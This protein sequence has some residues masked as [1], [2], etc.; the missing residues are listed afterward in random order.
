MSFIRFCCCV[1]NVKQLLKAKFV[2]YY[3]MTKKDAYELKSLHN[4]K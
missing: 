1:F 4:S 2:V 3:V